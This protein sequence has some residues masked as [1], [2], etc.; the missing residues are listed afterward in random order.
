MERAQEMV[1]LCNAHGWQIVA[2][3]E[4]DEPED[5][6][7]IERLLNPSESHRAGQTLTAAPPHVCQ[8]EPCPC[9]SGRKYK[10]CCGKE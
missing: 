9:G 6:T 5:I 2:G 10:N 8:N 7:D 1:F 4:P 3:I